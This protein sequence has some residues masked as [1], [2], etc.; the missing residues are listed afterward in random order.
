MKTKALKSFLLIALVFS[1]FSISYAYEVTGTLSSSNI[2]TGLASN[3]GRGSFT[4]SGST[5]TGVSTINGQLASDSSL[6]GTVVSPN[7]GSNISSGGGV[8]SAHINSG[9]TLLAGTVAPTSGGGS[10]LG[11]STSTPYVG[12][13]LSA[14]GKALETSSNSLAFSN[15]GNKTPVLATNTVAQADYSTPALDTSSM[16]AAAAAGAVGNISTAS[17]IW[18]ILLSLLLIATIIY[19]VRNQY[20]A[21]IKRV[22]I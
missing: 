12:N 3:S 17:W 11:V 8:T 14:D 7:N 20:V 19:I 2:Q 1:F 6:S 21:K 5:S 22:K 15:V 9:N 4:S 10:V 16:Q 18:I 13:F